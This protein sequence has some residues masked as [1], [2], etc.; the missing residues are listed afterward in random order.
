MTKAPDGLRR[1]HRAGA[2]EGL[3]L[4]GVSGTSVSSPG[5]R[6]HHRNQGTR[7]PPHRP[8]RSTVNACSLPPLTTILLG[9]SRSRS[10]SDG[11]ERA[12][13]TRILYSR[14][15]SRGPVTRGRP[16]VVPVSEDAT[17]PP[18]CSLRTREQLESPLQGRF[19]FRFSRTLDSRIFHSK[20]VCS[21]S[22][23]LIWVLS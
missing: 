6:G 15:S 9:S 19:C 18:R 4:P 5:G 2:R 12:P 17:C 20:A 13:R 3:L 14:L 11:L 1:V 7:E 10:P 16:D 8:V 21:F 22:A 23:L